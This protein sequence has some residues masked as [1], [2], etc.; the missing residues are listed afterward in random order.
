[1]N[2]LVLDDSFDPKQHDDYFLQ[3]AQFVSDGLHSCGY[4]YCSGDIMA[5]NPK[6]RQPLSQWKAYFNDWI[7][8]PSPE[9]LLHSSIFFDL[10]GV[11]V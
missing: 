3:L 9:K 5:T 10:D 2:A 4:T 11:G 1:D 7:D 6:W 8:N